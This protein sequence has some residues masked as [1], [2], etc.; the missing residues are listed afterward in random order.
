M[1]KALLVI[2][3]LAGAVL[4]AQTLERR[5]SG[6]LDFSPNRARGLTRIV[7]RYD[8]YHELAASCGMP[9]P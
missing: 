9:Q 2:V 8:R 1:K 4:A 6:V 7:A 3:T 5:G